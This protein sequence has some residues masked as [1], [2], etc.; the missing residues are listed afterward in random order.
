LNTF[1]TQCDAKKTE[2]PLRC[3]AKNRPAQSFIRCG[4]M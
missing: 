4:Q 2:C 3:W 1:N